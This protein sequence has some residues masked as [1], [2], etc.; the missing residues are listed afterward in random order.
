MSTD[1]IRD[2]MV[3]VGRLREMV[4]MGLK[5][6]GTRYGYGR[7]DELVTE[8][9]HAMGLAGDALLTCDYCGRATDEL[10]TSESADPSV[11]YRDAMDLCRDCD[12]GFQRRGI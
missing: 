9:E 11:G 4:D 12:K 6:D 3:I 8:L 10:I 1:T 5:V 7:L 2:P